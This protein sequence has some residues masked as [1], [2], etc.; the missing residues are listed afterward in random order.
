MGSCRVLGVDAC[1]GGWAGIVLSDG[2][3]EPYFAT[4]ISDLAE[5]AGGGG[6]LDLIAVD[7]P[8]GLPD[9]GRRRADVLAR[10]LAG[11]RWASVFMTPVRSAL[12]EEAH[13]AATAVNVQLAGEG[14][15][16]QAHGLRTKILQ[17]DQ[18]VRQARQRVVEVHP[19][20]SFACLAGVPLNVG[21]S[22]WAGAARR[23]QL[24]AG[25]GIVLD[26][27]LGLAGERA[28]V[29]DILDAAVAAW[30]A[31]RVTR[32]QAQPVPDPPEVFSDGLPCAIWA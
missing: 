28:G 3:A 13:A 9:A 21:K 8:I 17:V 7:M 19:E 24:L 16:R 6:P 31:L 2:P 20:V 5:Q 10:E 26:D 1:K 12:Q 4:A 30:T 18:W 27:D 32:G 25:A 22:T 11:P 29:D 23:R 14:I 15:S